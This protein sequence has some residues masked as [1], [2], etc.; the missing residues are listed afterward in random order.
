MSTIVLVLP[1]AQVVLNQGRAVTTATVTNTAAVPARIVLGAFAPAG[2][3]G[4]PAPPDALAWTT[5]DRPLRELGPGV[6]EQYTVTFAPAAE[7]APGTYSA[8][9]IAYSAD[10]A[11]EENSDQARQLDV[12]V[13]AVP[14]TPAPGPGIPWWVYV[15][16]GALVVTVAV[17]A[18]LLLRPGA[19]PEPSPSPSQSPT[20][21]VTTAAPVQV[22]G[23][24][25]KFTGFDDGGTLVPVVPG[26]EPSLTVEGDRV[27]GSTGCNRYSGAWAQT[28]NDVTI[29]PL[30]TTLRLCNPEAV[31]EQERRFLDL[32]G[33][34]TA[35]AG[36]G[37]SIRL[38][39]P[40]GTAL[41]FAR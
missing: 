19:P 32:L 4:S 23:T 7:V 17:V 16:A 24:A 37:T 15:V 38:T 36:D 39:A 1:V 18:F 40:D 5:V 33:R 26:T 14:A 29:G 10:G 2:P 41:V 25:W 12:V 30:G 9:F 13:P 22:E 27:S 28:G 21:S 6:T 11:P 3:A 34:A 35:V 20:P 31:R 8:R